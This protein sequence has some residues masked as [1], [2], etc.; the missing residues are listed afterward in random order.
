MFERCLDSNP[1]SYRSKQAC[2]QVGHPSHIFMPYPDI[3]NQHQ[4]LW[5][6]PN[7]LFDQ[8]FKKHIPFISFFCVSHT[9]VV[10][11]NKY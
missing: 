7:R 9:S 5:L 10:L 8:I 3:E 11:R 4:H 1:E 6:G 2:Y